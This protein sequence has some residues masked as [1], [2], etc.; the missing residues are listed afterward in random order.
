[1][2]HVLPSH[3]GRET[4]VA[5][6][7]ARLGRRT[8][9]LVTRLRRGEIALIHHEDLDGAAAR[10]LAACRP[11]AVLNSAPFTSGRYANSGPGIL[12]EAGIPLLELPDAAVWEQVA[13]GEPLQWRGETLYRAG[14]PVAS[15]TRLTPDLLAERSQAESAARAAGIQ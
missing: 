3:A 2:R 7:R 5:A 1:M 8:K 13:E 12:L 6:G 11:A 9:E 10:A 4:V 15:G 14:E